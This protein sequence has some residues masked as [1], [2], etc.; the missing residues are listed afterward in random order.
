MRRK[1]SARPRK[2]H[3]NWRWPAA[4]LALAAVLAGCSALPKLGLP[5]A[6]ISFS[7][8]ADA[9]VQ[10]AA[11][12]PTAAVPDVQPAPPAVATPGVPKPAVPTPAAPDLRTLQ[13]EI[14]DYVGRQDGTYGVYVIDIASGKGTGVN[15]DMKFPTAST[16]KLP[17]AMYILNQVELGKAVLDQ[18]LS[19][20]AED[21]EEGTGTLQDSVS[22]G[23]SFTVKELIDLAITQSDNIA[24]NMLLRRFGRENVYAYMKKLGGKVTIYSDPENGSTTGTTPKEMANYMRLAYGKTAIGDAKL[25]Q[26]LL[27]LLTHTAFDDRAAAGVPRG[28]KVAHK[29]GTLPNVVND[30]A[31]VY[32]PRRTFVVAVYSVGVEEETAAAVIAEVTRRVYDFERDLSTSAAQQNPE[33]SVNGALPK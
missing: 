2:R 3:I 6:V 24:T 16:F 10:P 32:A 13:Q 33:T 9:Q 5:S 11:P 20:S 7:G 25:R 28:V 22:E 31:L 8:R 19:Y 21:Y 4:A 26:F 27:D 17:M 1:R 29:I 15:A 30:V 23:D 14:S 18:S 12:A